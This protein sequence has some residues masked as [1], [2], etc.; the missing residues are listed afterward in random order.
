M[1]NW[2]NKYEE[3]EKKIMEDIN[4][5]QLDEEIVMPSSPTPE[6]CQYLITKTQAKINSII[7]LKVKNWNGD[8]SVRSIR[9]D[10][11]LRTLEDYHSKIRNRCQEL[12]IEIPKKEQ[13]EKQQIQK[14]IDTQKNHDLDMLEARERILDK[15]MELERMRWKHNKE[16]I[17][18][19]QG[20]YD[21]MKDE[22]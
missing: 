22:L 9:A 19:M 12:M 4:L 3:E 1:G 14:E 11:R 5:F 15:E 6:D 18:E 20:F 21:Q 2:G 17:E 16:D 7:Q 8:G 10:S 13:E